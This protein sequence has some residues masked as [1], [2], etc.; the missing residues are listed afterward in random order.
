MTNTLGRELNYS[1]IQLL[2]NNCRYIGEFR[3]HDVIIPNGIPGIVP[4]DLFDSVQ[5]KMAKN[6]KTPARHKRQ[7]MIICSQQNCSEVTAVLISAAKVAQGAIVFIIITNMSMPRR[8][9]PARGN[10]FKRIGWGFW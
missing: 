10:L 4:Q 9:R 5:E 8:K 1:S 7:R 6:K 2:L 3:C